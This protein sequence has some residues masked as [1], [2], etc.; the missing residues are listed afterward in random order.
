MLYWFILSFAFIGTS[1][2][3]NFAV[4]EK[5]QIVLSG[6][7]NLSKPLFPSDAMVWDV[8]LEDT[9]AETIGAMKD[10]GK[11]VICYFSAGTYENWRPDSKKFVANDMGTTLREW[12]NER[13]LRLT[14]TNVRNIMKTR[15]DNA[16]KKGCDAIDPDNTDAY[17]NSNGLNMKET[18]S[19]AYMQFLASYAKSQGL[20]I[21]LKN[22]LSIIPSLTSV[23]SFAVNEECA[24]FGECEAYNNFIK[25]GKPVYHIEYIAKPPQITAAEK[26][27]SCNSKGMEGFSTVMKN[28]TLSGWVTYCDG[29]SATTDTTP[30]GVIPGKPPQHTTLTSTTTKPTSDPTSTLETATDPTTFEITT[31]I[32]TTSKTTPKP[33][34]KTSTSTSKK[35]TTTA[36]NGGGGCI[37]KHWDQCGGKDW[38]G[39]TQCASGFQCKGV[40]PPYYYQCL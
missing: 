9:S 5:F 20:A 12:P 34:S 30:G 22:S 32:P 27:L 31:S 29:S 40:S 17:Q 23:M 11:T 8:D 33:T 18:D 36:A 7:P 38:K 19:V 16:A 13:W 28:M 24:K 21:G 15:I 2:G 26:A 4:G 25:A 1:L 14:S 35:P 37:S 10:L 39:C 3:S 6:I